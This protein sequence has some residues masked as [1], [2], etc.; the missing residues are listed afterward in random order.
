VFGLEQARPDRPPDSETPARHPDIVAP[1]AR[2]ALHMERSDS[3]QTAL[4][5]GLLDQLADLRAA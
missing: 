3:E 1:R 2:I 4:L 5:T